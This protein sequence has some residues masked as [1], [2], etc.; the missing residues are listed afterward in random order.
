MKKI[1]LWL[2]IALVLVAQ[3]MAYL[4]FSHPSSEH[5][6]YGNEVITVAENKPVEHIVQ[7]AN[8][9]SSDIDVAVKISKGEDFARIDGP[10]N[11][12]VPGKSTYDKK[13]IIILENNGKD[14]CSIEPFA[15]VIEPHSNN[16]DSSGGTGAGINV[17]QEKIKRVLFVSD[18]RS[19]TNVRSAFYYNNKIYF[20]GINDMSHT[21][22]VKIGKNTYSTENKSIDVSDLEKG[23]HKAIIKTI[24]CEGDTSDELTIEFNNT[25]YSYAGFGLLYWPYFVGGLLAVL[26]IVALVRFIKV[27]MTKKEKLKEVNFNEQIDF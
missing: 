7:Y 23:E 22:N 8:S 5:P 14:V 9:D 15:F 1:L 21:I 11:F 19:S 26:V 6:L 12:V 27:P 25:K 4:S 20:K 18:D 10:A 24:D 3:A 2:I 16:K 17:A 13:T